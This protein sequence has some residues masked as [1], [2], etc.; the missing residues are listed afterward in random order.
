MSRLMRMALEEASNGVAN[1]EI[2]KVY[3]V[4]FENTDFLKGIGYEHQEQWS[5][6]LPKTEHNSASGDIRIRAT[7]QA[8]QRGLWEYVLTTKTIAKSGGGKIEV[9][10]PTT[11]DNFE[12]FKTLAERGMRK[13]R[14]TIP[15]EGTSLK[16]EIDLFLLPDSQFGEN[17]Y[18]PWAKVDIECDS[19]STVIPEFPYPNLQI[20]TEPYG[21]RSTEEETLVT[22]LY[23][24][25]FV[26]Y[27]TAAKQEGT[28]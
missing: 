27:N 9:A 21:S 25:E 8:G 26:T 18:W 24:N 2:E 5:I 14:Y 13:D 12:Q 15:I 28:V 3:Y 7:Y 19:L 1:R 10:I 6:K 23:S 17:K 22:G 16:W 11:K 20:I 4:K